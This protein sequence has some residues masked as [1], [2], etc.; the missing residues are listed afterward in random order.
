M[1]ISTLRTALRV[2]KGVAK[3]DENLANL[4]LAKEQ[5]IGILNE[6]NKDSKHGWITIK[7]E[8]IKIKVPS[9]ENWKAI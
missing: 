9:D 2:I 3:Q 4:R 5:N 7:L 6:K 8:A 1:N